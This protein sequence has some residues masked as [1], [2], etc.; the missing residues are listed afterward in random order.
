[1]TCG[2]YDGWSGL[3]SDM[4]QLGKLVQHINWAIH[5][6]FS[7]PVMEVKW[8]AVEKQRGMFDASFW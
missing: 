2:D 3:R 4:G 5:W 6:E 7:V 1:M 8:S